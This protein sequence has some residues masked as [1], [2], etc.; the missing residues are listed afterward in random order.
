[1]TGEIRKEGA[2]KRLGKMLNRKPEKIRKTAR[3]PKMHGTGRK[4][5]DFA[6]QRSFL[7]A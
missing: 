4:P 6:G 5:V 2:G 7:K 1:M 3:M